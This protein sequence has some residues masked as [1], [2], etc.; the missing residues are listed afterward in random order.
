M[1]I[2][3]QQSSCENPRRC[4]GDRRAKNVRP[5]LEIKSSHQLQIIHGKP[6]S[7]RRFQSLRQ[8][9][10]RLFSIAGTIR[11]LLF[12]MNDVEPK[13]E[14]AGYKMGVDGAIGCR[15]QLLMRIPAKRYELF[16]IHR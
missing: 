4:L 12:K 1:T 15:N 10:K 5:K 3:M 14:V 13:Q 8:C 6:T 2:W 7:R 11:P 16:K 9:L